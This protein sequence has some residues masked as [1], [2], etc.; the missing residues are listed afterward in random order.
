MRRCMKKY[1][2]LKKCKVLLPF[3]QVKRWFRLAFGKD[4]KNVSRELKANARLRTDKKER[5]EKLLKDL[6]L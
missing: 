6:D 1:P 3:Y 2:N 4:S 5:I